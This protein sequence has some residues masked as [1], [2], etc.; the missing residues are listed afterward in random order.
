MWGRGIGGTGFVH[1]APTREVTGK[2]G[3]WPGVQEA[4]RHL[5]SCGAEVWEPGRGN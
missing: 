5:R 1:R 3:A 4:A 2:G